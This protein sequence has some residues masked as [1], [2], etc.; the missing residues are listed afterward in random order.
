MAAY[1]VAKATPATDKLFAG[2]AG[3]D[4]TVIQLARGTADEQ[5]ATPA[6]VTPTTLSEGVG[7]VITLTF[8]GATTYTVTLDGGTPIVM[9]SPTAGTFVEGALTGAGLFAGE[10]AWARVNVDAMSAMI[11]TG[12][13]YTNNIQVI[14]RG[15]RI[16]TAVTGVDQEAYGGVYAMEYNVKKTIADFVP[17]LFDNH[18][19]VKTYHGAIT[20]AMSTDYLSWGSKPYFDMGGNTVY[21]VPLKDYSILGTGYEIYDL[22]TDG[23]Y[24]AAIEDALELLKDIPEVTCVLPLAPVEKNYR[25]G[26][27]NAVKNHV[28]QMSSTVNNKPRISILGARSGNTFESTIKDAVQ[29]IKDRRFVYP[30]ISTATKTI[31]S[32]T[33]TCNGATIA[34]S[35]AGLLSSGI[36]AGTPISGKT[37][38]AFD[39]I[40][41]PFTRT[42]KDRL[43]EV[44]GA[45]VIENQGGV[46]TIVHFLSTDTTDTLTSEAKVAVIETDIRNTLTSA[47]NKLIINTRFTPQTIG[48]VSSLIGM[49]LAQKTTIGVIEDFKIVSVVRNTTEARQLDVKLQVLPMLD[50]NWLY[51][52]MQFATAS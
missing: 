10:I 46:P 7:H 8:D 43:G 15:P 18:A 19:D 30:S 9:V 13:T 36:D 1:R 5:F 27:V 12:T 14:T 44:Y 23:G 52:D 39:S 34:S 47:L 22:S 48:T 45:C 24:Q 51:I 3:D 26:I 25:P 16:G 2:A 33:K 40:T 37:I 4:N 21:I 49:L 20:D 29:Y 28:N 17:A 42:Q 11:T 6:S 38:T 41:D 32:F 35:I 31:D 50:V